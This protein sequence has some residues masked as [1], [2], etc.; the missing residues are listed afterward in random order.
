MRE[1]EVG[2]MRG[3][4]RGLVVVVLGVALGGCAARATPARTATPVVPVGLE[5]LNG[6]VWMQTAVEYE[7]AARLAYHAA[8]LALERALADPSWTA[9][10]EQTGDFHRLPPAVVLDVDETVLDNSVHQARLVA[11]GRVYNEP[12]WNA[13]CE[14]RAATAVPGA[15]E[16]TRAAAARGVTVFYL[17]NREAAVKAATRDNLAQLG[18]PLDPARDTLLTKGERPEWAGSEKASRRRFIARDY[19]ILLLIGD[20]Y[21]DFSEGARRPLAERRASAEPHR[22]WW[23]ERWFMLPNPNYGTWERALVGPGEDAIAAKRRHLVTG[24]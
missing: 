10:T 22:S 11:D 8:G 13:W 5:Q 2:S 21:G 12:Q 20:D 1:V 3:S 7:A 15:L 19:R 18:F 9:A 17:T 14:E 23:G 16:F 4:A 24:R 6:V